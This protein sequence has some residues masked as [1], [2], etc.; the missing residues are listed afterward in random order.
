MMAYQ[1]ELAGLG[2]ALIWALASFIY[3][4]LGKQMPPLVLN[5][6]K[7]SVAIGLILLTLAVQGDLQPQMSLANLGWLL[8]SGAIGIGFG[9]TAYFASLNC[10]GARRSL[11]MESLAPPLAALLAAVFLEEQLT[12]Q[13]W[14]GIGLTVSGVAWVV[15][16]RTPDAVPGEFRPLRGI[17]FGAL[18]ALGQAGGAVLSRAALAD[19]AV[20]PLWSTLIRL[21]AG[22]LVLFLL[23]LPQRQDWARFQPIRSPRFLTV[24]VATS[25]FGTYL[26]IWLQQIALKYTATGIAQALTSTSPLFVLPIAALLREK[27][28]LRAVLG[29]F[30]ALTGVWLLLR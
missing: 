21:V 16:E 6:T 7:S 17:G 19:T 28:S 1:G 12:V 22:V 25:F 5:F 9:D 15:A 23:I 2:A 29:V 27:I 3:V 13:V 11:L 24:L 14:L 10:L 4:S 18:A 30:V 26:A 20:S 8:L